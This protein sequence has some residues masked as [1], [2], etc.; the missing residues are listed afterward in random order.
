VSHVF[1][2][3]LPQDAEDYVHRI[4]RTARAGASGDA[5]SFGCENYAISL[6]DIENY[7]GQKIPVTEIDRSELATVAET[8]ERARPRPRKPR[9]D[10]SR[11]P[12]GRRSGGSNRDRRPSGGAQPSRGN[13]SA[14]KAE[15]RAE[16]KPDSGE[17]TS[18]GK[19]K[20]R[21]R[22]RPRQQNPGQ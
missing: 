16:S 6:P 9:S 2:Y 19:K 17:S 21:R 12:G 22:R 8:L 5:I 13:D 7:I 4:G 18:E 1:N 14:K 10:S 11:R 15:P 3:D 20:R